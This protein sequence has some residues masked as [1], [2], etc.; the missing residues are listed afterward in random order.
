MI[1]V[2]LARYKEEQS[3]SWEGLVDD[4]Q[5]EALFSQVAIKDTNYRFV[6]FMS[7]SNKF[8]C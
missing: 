1:E 7:V 2:G 5:A 8:S 6:S 4:Q 3:P